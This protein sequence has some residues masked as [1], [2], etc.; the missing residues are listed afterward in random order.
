MQVSGSE[1][2]SAHMHITWS[3]V[4]RLC[5]EEEQGEADESQGNQSQECFLN[6]SFALPL[7]LSGSFFLYHRTEED[8][9]SRTNG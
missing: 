6:M 4:S 5:K 7:S 8:K 2:G 9:K 1:N 3:L